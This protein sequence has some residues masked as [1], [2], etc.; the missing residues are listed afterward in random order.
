MNSN[1]SSTGC[2]PLI[3]ACTLALYRKNI[4]RIT[5]LPVDA[6]AREVSK[7]VQRLQMIE[8]MGGDPAGVRPGFSLPD[9]PDRWEI[10]D[11]LARMKEPKHRL[12]DEFF[13]FWPERF[14]ASKED[15]A[16]QAIL[17]GESDR[18]AAIWRTLEKEGSFVAQHNLA[19]MYHMSAIDW[20]NHQIEHGLDPELNDKIRGYWKKSFERW[21]PMI[22]ADSLWDMLKERVRTLNDEALTTG[23]VRRMLQFLPQALDRV[24]A[25]AALKLA[26]QENMDWARFHVEFMRETHAGL[27]D[28]ESTAEMVLAPTKRRVEA[29]LK[30]SLEEGREAPSRGSELA[31][32][33]MERCRPMMSLFDLFHGKEAHQRNELFDEVGQAVLE[34]LVG[35][36]RATDDNKA[37]VKILKEALEFSSGSHLRE[38]IIKNISIGE[39]NLQGQLLEPLFKGLRAITD[40]AQTPAQKL[41][42]VKSQVLTKLPKLAT[43]IGAGSSAYVNMMDT[44][45]LAMREISIDAH[46]DASDFRTA[47]AALNL[48]QELAVGKELRDRIRGDIVTLTESK[49]NSMC[50]FCG[51]NPGNPA[52]T[53]KIG[54]YGDVVQGYGRVDYRTLNVPIQCCTDCAK[55]FSNATGAGYAV[56]V[57]ALALGLLIGFAKGGEFVFLMGGAGAVVGFVL[58]VVVKGV[59]DFTTGKNKQFKHPEVRALKAKGWRIGDNPSS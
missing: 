55:K 25:E 32:Q 28:V 48:A 52:L 8:E 39:G 13:W 23:F 58:Y 33:L 14:G 16:M 19:V 35:H 43:K 27:D 7:Q 15:P 36:Q 40:S 42:W 38:R 57:F 59:L 2:V 34:M 21:E 18:A 5:G 56:G 17:A 11:A 53:F 49:K 24:N 10:R 51:M 30:S 6:T 31:T 44:L 41:A 50:Y 45:A 1:L 54:M 37:F 47:E 26:E 12:V 46:N 20:T 29:H 4:F 9:P 3:E 22:D